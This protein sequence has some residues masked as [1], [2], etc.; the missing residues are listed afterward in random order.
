MKKILILVSFI[1]CLTVIS[2]SGA[3]GTETASYFETTIMPVL[4]DW[5]VVVVGVVGGVMAVYRKQKT[6]NN[7]MITD[8]ITKNENVSKLANEVKASSNSYAKSSDEQLKKV[9]QL[10]VEV[11][12]QHETINNLIKLVESHETDRINTTKKYEMLSNAT[13]VILGLIANNEELVRNNYSI[14]IMKVIE[15]VKAKSSEI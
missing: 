1:I 11:E 7:A 5:G 14:E 3:D 13:L 10:M 9:Y 8:S 15:D 2:V 6:L 4:I 12:K